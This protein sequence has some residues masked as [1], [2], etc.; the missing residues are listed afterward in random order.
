MSTTTTIRLP[1]ELKALVAKV[2][3]A[4]GMTPH[5]FIVEAVAEKAADAEA[6]QAFHALAQQRLVDFKR[7]GKSVPWADM[8]EYMRDKAAGRPAKRPKARK[9]AL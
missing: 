7:S 9:L 1:D 2:A 8:R 4:A 3:D 6:R 5:G